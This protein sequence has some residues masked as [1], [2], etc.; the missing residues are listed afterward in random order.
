M[1][2]FEVLGKNANFPWPLMG[3]IDAHGNV[4]IEPQF[5]QIS[6]GFSGQFSE[7]GYAFVKRSHGKQN[8]IINTSGE[9][10]LVLPGDH[11]PIAQTPPDE[12]GIFGVTH[13]VGAN[14]KELWH[15]EG[16]DREFQGETRYYAMRLDGSIA[17][18]AHLLDAA[19]G[20]YVFLKDGNLNGPR[21][22]INHKGQII[23]PPI[24]D[25]IY[26]SKMG[27]YATVL[28][29]GFANV[30]T[31]EGSAVFRDPVEIG[32][33]ADLRSVE[34]G[35]WVAP[36]RA[37]GC[38][39]VFDV[40]ST[41]AIGTLPMTYWSPMIREACPTLS[42]GVALINHPEKGS[43]Y[44]FPDGRAAMPGIQRKPRWF[45]SE[46]RTGYFHEGRASFKLGEVW[47]YMD[48]SGKYVIEPQ[49]SSDLPFRD[50]L[51]RVKY[52]S[53][54]NSWN[55]YSYVNC[56]GSVVWHQED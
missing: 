27:P 35:L 22:L 21:G 7:A 36:T 45:E 40:A 53:D 54:G 20:H 31:F 50:G 13:E 5:L 55:R 17:F 52:P 9:T 39:S 24:Y 37:K 6:R 19:I 30:F 1:P 56:E 8:L 18:E 29:D 49:F 11:Q 42:G 23:I 34:N 4:V 46:M 51:A 15:V 44:F 38:A 10:V 47:G 16:R 43:T 2:L 33:S 3:F 26:L 12:H 32:S 14:N 25:A 28:K 48:L 41:E